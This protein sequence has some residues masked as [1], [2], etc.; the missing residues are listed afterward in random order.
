VDYRVT[1]DHSNGSQ[2]GLTMGKVTNGLRVEAVLPDG[3]VAIWNANNPAAQIEVGDV[4]MCVNGALDCSSMEQ[5][6]DKMEM[7]CIKLRR[8]VLVQDTAESKKER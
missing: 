2:Y 1:I 5:E 4:I 8:H 6:L 7:M 3:L